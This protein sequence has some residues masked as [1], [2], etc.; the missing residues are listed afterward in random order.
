MNLY[1]L[2]SVLNYN[3]ITLKMTFYKEFLFY[4]NFISL[5]S[6]IPSRLRETFKLKVNADV[7]GSKFLFIFAHNHIKPNKSHFHMLS[8]AT[9][10][11]TST[12]YAEDKCF[13]V[14]TQRMVMIMSWATFW[15]EADCRALTVL[16]KL[17]NCN[18]VTKNHIKLSY[19]LFSSHNIADY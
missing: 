7:Y 18:W 10:I 17:W 11:F 4:F 19:I 3:T 2:G 12:L 16:C 9:T 8:A 1:G 5:L 14:I 6:N 15:A 13:I